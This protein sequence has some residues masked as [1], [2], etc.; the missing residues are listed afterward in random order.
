[1]KAR[2]YK[3]AAKLPEISDS[4]REMKSKKLNSIKKE[5][6]LAKEYRMYSGML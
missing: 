4:Y 1:M 3:L 6:F 2:T 5:D